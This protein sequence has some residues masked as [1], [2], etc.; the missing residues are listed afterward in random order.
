M[1]QQAQVPH[2]VG[3]HIPVEVVTETLPLALRSRQETRDIATC[4]RLLAQGHVTPYVGIESYLTGMQFRQTIPIDRYEV[5]TLLV[6]FA[7]DCAGVLSRV[8]NIRRRREPAAV[9]QLA[10]PVPVLKLCSAGKT[11][12]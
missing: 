10:P 11:S 12:S 3:Q 9:D 8:H 4:T 1:R 7:L 6:L 2:F 5:P